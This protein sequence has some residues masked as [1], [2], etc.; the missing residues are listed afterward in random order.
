L[1]DEGR[2]FD[3]TWKHYNDANVVFHPHRMT[4]DQLRDGYIRMW[5]EFYGRHADVAAEEDIILNRVQF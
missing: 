3:R 5:K 1:E 2:I 4:A